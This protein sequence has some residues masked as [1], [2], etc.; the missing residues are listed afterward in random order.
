MKIKIDEMNIHCDSAMI[1]AISD[2]GDESATCEIVLKSLDPLKEMLSLRSLLGSLANRETPF[3]ELYL[4]MQKVIALALEETMNI[5]V[6]GHSIFDIDPN[7]R[8]N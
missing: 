2:I 8:G 7:A 3:T 1:A 4:G 5:D 6:H